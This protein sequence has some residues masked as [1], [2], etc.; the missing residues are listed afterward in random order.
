MRRAEQPLQRRTQ[1]WEQEN[2]INQKAGL[3]RWKNRQEASAK[4]KKLEKTVGT[5]AVG[6][7][8]KLFI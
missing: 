6:T 2:C 4:L 7:A 5:E 3:A 1:P 8:R